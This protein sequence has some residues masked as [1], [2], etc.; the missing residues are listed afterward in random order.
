M[1][2]LLGHQIL[3][4]K[5][6]TL[7]I[8]AMYVEHSKNNETFFCKKCLPFKFKFFNFYFSSSQTLFVKT[9]ITFCYWACKFRVFAQRIAQKWILRW[10]ALVQVWFCISNT[11]IVLLNQKFNYSICIILSFTKFVIWAIVSLVYKS[12]MHM[13]KKCNF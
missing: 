1:F 7:I 9:N 11:K 3:A 12:L 13:W 10:L 4:C 6:R 5:S 8:L 2:S